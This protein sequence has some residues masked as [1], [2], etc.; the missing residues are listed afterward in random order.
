MNLAGIK[1]AF[2]EENSKSINLNLLESSLQ[3]LYAEILERGLGWSLNQ[4]EGSSGCAW[5]Q[6]EATTLW[7]VF[8]VEK[9]L[10][11]AKVRCM[12]KLVKAAWSSQWNLP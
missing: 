5:L 2:T 7:R 6:K 9:Q 4:R 12:Q 8:Y 1:R 11:M 10:L 3:K